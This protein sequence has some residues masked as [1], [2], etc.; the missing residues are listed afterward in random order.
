MQKKTDTSERK[1][2]ANLVPDCSQINGALRSVNDK[3]MLKGRLS[4]LLARFF[5]GRSATALADQ[6]MISGSNFLTNI[7]L[8]RGLGLEEYG[9]YSIAYV[10]LL[11]AN[12]L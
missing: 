9:K 6:V 3:Q 4:G 12:A 1:F 5:R 11:Y 8:V 7:V 2:E 10:L